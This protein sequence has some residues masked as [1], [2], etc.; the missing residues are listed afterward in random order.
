MTYNSRLKDET[1]DRLFEAVLLL[2]NEEE[3]YRFF[4]DICTVGEIKAIAQRLEVA[5]MLAREQIYTDI[6]EK[7]GASTAT[8]SRVKRS[9]YFGADG[10]RLILNRL[11]EKNQQ[12]KDKE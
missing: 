11:Q 5:K 4:E 7:T 6:V 2:E 1:T 10:Y 12:E 3:C 9:L 8:I